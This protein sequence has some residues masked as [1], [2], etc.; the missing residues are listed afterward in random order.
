MLQDQLTFCLYQTVLRKIKIPVGVYFLKL[1]YRICCIDV[2]M[3][4][5]KRKEDKDRERNAW[6]YCFLFFSYVTILCV[7]KCASM[8][9]HQ[10]LVKCIWSSHTP[11]TPLPDSLLF[12][13][14]SC[15]WCCFT[16]AEGFRLHVCVCM[17]VWE[18]VFVQ[19]GMSL[20]LCK[21]TKERKRGVR[22]EGAKMHYGN[23][24]CP[25]AYSSRYKW[26]S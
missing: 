12:I 13:P 11:P 4:A 24:V 5:S 7:I 17:R 14:C 18:C 2:C 23:N 25:D 3:W 9:F 10:C 20:C 21:R 22:W 19:G 26:V 16:C 15:P 8:C 1:Q 6:I